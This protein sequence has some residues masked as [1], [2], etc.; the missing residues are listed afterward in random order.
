MASAEPGAASGEA[1]TG[2]NGSA[3]GE[4]P[5]AS[6]AADGS[7]AA[8]SGPPAAP[9]EE[10]PR[11]HSS[12]INERIADLKKLQQEQKATRQRVAK[13]LRNEER[14]RR[15]LKERA[16]QLTDEDLLAVL[17]LRR[18][19]KRGPE[20]ASQDTAAN[21][22]ETVPRADSAAGSSQDAPSNE[23]CGVRQ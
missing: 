3:D 4:Q 9:A 12:S 21:S 18:G 5:H 16:K 14:K 17:C 23:G 11:L 8:A 10:G 15:R 6:S 19:T 22:Q 2:A 7:A 13:E 20:S 1:C